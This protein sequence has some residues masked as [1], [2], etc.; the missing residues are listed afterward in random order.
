MKNL[1]YALT[2]CSAILTVLLVSAITQYYQ[3]FLVIL[4]ITAS[5]TFLFCLYLIL[6]DR[7]LYN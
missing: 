2:V 7:K 3:D 4:L 6:V 5:L 1:I